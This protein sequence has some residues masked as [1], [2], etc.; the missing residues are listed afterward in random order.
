MSTSAPSSPRAIG[1][2]SN[3]MGEVTAFIPIAYCAIPRRNR[4]SIARN[5]LQRPK[6]NLTCTRRNMTVITVFHIFTD[7]TEAFGIRPSRL[8]RSRKSPSGSISS[9]MTSRHFP[10][11]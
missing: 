1:A 11:C 9:A 10:W 3:F 2:A 8:T 5:A 4:P 7:S 6:S